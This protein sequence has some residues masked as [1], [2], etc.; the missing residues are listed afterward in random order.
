MEFW[1]GP[2]QDT[3]RPN[4]S[5]YHFCKIFCWPR[6]LKCIDVHCALLCILHYYASCTIPLI[7]T[8]CLP[9]LCSSLF[10]TG[11][12]CI[13]IS[14]IMIGLRF[15]FSPIEQMKGALNIILDTCRRVHDLL[16]TCPQYG[17]TLI[18]FSSMCLSMNCIPM[19]I[20]GRFFMKRSSSIIIL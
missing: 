9:L 18:W 7:R 10:S 11:L 19:N 8:W 14:W 17:E 6:S 5:V 12:W 13:L 16:C 2:K 4:K 3:W 20:Y 1:N 15:D